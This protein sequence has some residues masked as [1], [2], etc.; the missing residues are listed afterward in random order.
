[1]RVSWTGF[2]PL[3]LHSKLSMPWLGMP[4]SLLLLKSAHGAPAFHFVGGYLLVSNLCFLSSWH[5]HLPVALQLMAESYILFCGNWIHRM[6]YCEKI[7]LL[8]LWSKLSAFR[9]PAPTIEKMKAKIQI[10]SH[11]K[12]YFTR[13]KVQRPT[14]TWKN[15]QDH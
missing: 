2:F 11:K 12:S 10:K 13:W 8:K 14:D 1:M 7:S 3:L 6:I 4:Y 15:V 9:M 5:I